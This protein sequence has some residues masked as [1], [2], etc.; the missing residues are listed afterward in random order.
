MK[1]TLLITKFFPPE[2]GGIQSYLYNLVLNLPKDK[3]FV[4]THNSS[5]GL[6]SFSSRELS[7]EI[8]RKLKSA[9]PLYD[10]KSTLLQIIDFDHKQPFKIIRSNFQNWLRYF[11]LTTFGLFFKARRIIKKEKI[12]KI[13]CGHLAIAGP[14]GFLLKKIYHLPYFIFTHGTEIVSL[15]ILN[16]QK[17]KI[18]KKILAE[19]EKIIVTTGFMNHYLRS[20]FQISPQ[21]I[22]KIPPGVDDKFFRPM[23]KKEIANFSLRRIG[24]EL[25]LTTPKTKLL[26]TC[27]RLV[28]RKN[29]ISVIR[30]LPK[31]IK[32]VPNVLYLIA[33]QGPEEE[34]LRQ[35]VKK[36]NLENYVKFLG[37]VKQEDLPSLYNLADIFI[38]PAKDIPQKGDIEG[39]GIVFLEAAACGVPCIAGNSG[40]Q[41]E[42]IQDGKTGFLVNPQDIS[43]IA[44]AILKI[45]KNPDLGKKLGKAG[46]IW[47]KENFNWKNQA[48]KLKKLLNT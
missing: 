39:F 20:E 6:V 5:L 38:M 27:G 14:V 12:E 23:D 31:I 8:E 4:M 44:K 2:R 22:V 47:V 32:Q 13:L 36:L 41:K 28:A 46:R 40:G 25:K 15:K 11:H 3:I 21:K 35:E 33:G 16:R 29:H 24:R 34:N 26:L 48:E 1:P 19:A 9:T 30:A 42:A 10:S 17:Q 45:L 18:F 7:T 43:E 37:E